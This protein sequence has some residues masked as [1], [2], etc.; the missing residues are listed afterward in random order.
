VRASFEKAIVMFGGGP[1]GH[2]RPQSLRKSK[3]LQRLI[4]LPSDSH[5]LGA[6]PSPA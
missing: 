3:L 4:G 6:S 2:I 5:A 1:F